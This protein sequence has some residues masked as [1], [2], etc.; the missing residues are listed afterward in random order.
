MQ[1]AR[2]RASQT[3]IRFW[4]LDSISSS[5]S[6]APSGHGVDKVGACR[7]RLSAVTGEST[8][9]RWAASAPARRPTTGSLALVVRPRA[10]SPWLMIRPWSAWMYSGRRSRFTKLSTRRCGMACRAARAVRST[11]CPIRRAARLTSRCRSSDSGKPSSRATS[12]ISPS[13]SRSKARPE[14]RC[15]ASR[16]SSSRS[17]GSRTPW[18]GRSVSQVAASARNMLM[19]RMPPRASLRSGSSRLAA[20]PDIRQ[21]SS[22]DASSSG[23][24]TRALP[25]QASSSAVRAPLTKAASPAIPRRSSRPTPALSSWPA[26]WAHSAGV[27]TE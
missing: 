5:A 8:R 3:G 7:P 24:R 19:S 4:P 12:A 27:R 10:T 20:S 2:S 11:A 14:L 1:P 18:C 9:P 13:S 22:N 26:T 16:T 21:R 15:R 17:Y 6:R 23:S 25:R